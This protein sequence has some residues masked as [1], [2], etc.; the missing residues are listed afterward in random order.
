[1]G[2]EVTPTDEPGPEW[3][4]WEKQL[5]SFDPAERGAAL[6]ALAG[7]AQRGCITLPPAGSDVNLHCHT[8]FSYN[9][10]GY[11]PSKFAWLARKVGMAVAGIVDFDVLDG[12]DEFREAGRLLRLKTCVGL[13]TR[14]Y[15]PE[16]SDKVMNSPGEP[17]ISYHMGVGFPSASLAPPE[18]QFVAHL[19]RTS[20]ERNRDLVRRVSNYL[21]PV[22]LDYDADVLP[23]TPS[24][25]ATERH[26]CLAYV[27]RA[28]AAFPDDR[29]LADFWTEKLEADVGKL[30]SLTGFGLQA[31][32][33]AR[34]MK[35]GGVGYVQPG[36]GSFPHLAETNRFLL[37]AGA[38]P[39]HTWLDGT[40]EGEQRMEELLH[41]VMAT[42][43][44][45][46]NVI[47]DRN[48]TPG[49]PD[50]KLANLGHVV[51]IAERL[52]LLVVA[53][54]EMNSPGH[55]LVDDF[56]SRELAPLLPV[57]LTSAYAV[58][59]H[60]V[61]EG[62]AGLGYMSP[63]AQRHF[64]GLA[65]RAAFFAQVGKTLPVGEEDCLAGLEEQ[66]RPELVLRRI[67]ARRTEMSQG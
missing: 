7:S 55:K 52:G 22:A 2:D 26:I 47:P 57:V 63:W 50:A 28:R 11:S 67:G 43:V 18:Q 64:P 53:G 36:E 40:S 65:D 39:T 49:R 8:F 14:V 12:L 45:A 60:S 10:Y 31:L 5:D 61:L 58:Y 62:Q 13:E 4:R 3:A 66:A 25:N 15:L 54:T 6:A 34:T 27:L 35:R 29:E 24:G 30:E 32:V 37:A 23:L 51:S 33:R 38:I 20:E 56:R 1:V 17:G 59:A 16:F 44:A 41:V 9:P 19:R 46:I 21:R 42:G 48:Y